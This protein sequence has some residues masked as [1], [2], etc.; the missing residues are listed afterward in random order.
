[1]TGERRKAT[2]LRH[3]FDF[4]EWFAGEISKKSVAAGAKTGVEG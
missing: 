4:L 3:F 1:V 2:V